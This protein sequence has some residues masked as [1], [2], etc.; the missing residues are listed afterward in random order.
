VERVWVDFR[1]TAAG[2]GTLGELAGSVEVGFGI[3][4]FD[5]CVYAGVAVVADEPVG[6]ARLY[7]VVAEFVAWDG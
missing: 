3:C 5:G 6:V 2:L 7:E 1:H 4:G